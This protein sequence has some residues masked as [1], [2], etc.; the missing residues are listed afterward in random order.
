VSNVTAHFAYRFQSVGKS[1]FAPGRV[2]VHVATYQPTVNRRVQWVFDCG[3]LSSERL[4]ANGLDALETGDRPA[5]TNVPVPAGVPEQLPAGRPPWLDLVVLSHFD[6]DHIGGVCELLKR[7][8]VDVFAL[9]YVPSWKRLLIATAEGVAGDEDLIQF[10]VDPVAFLSSLPGADIW[11][12]VLVPP[13]APTGPPLLPPGT[14]VPRLLA[15]MA[16]GDDDRLIVRI[17]PPPA[18]GVDP[19]AAGSFGTPAIGALAHGS[20]VRYRNV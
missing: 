10:F 17:D 4:V 16:T 8:S 2:D 18:P 14:S 13:S 5:Q 11:R 3:T 12:F 1:L 19:S 15:P 20:A 9:P 6:R 7:F